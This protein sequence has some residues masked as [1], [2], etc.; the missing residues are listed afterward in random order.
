MVLLTTTSWSTM[1]FILAFTS[2]IYVLI[3]THVIVCFNGS[4]YAMNPFCASWDQH[5]L[6][7]NIIVCFMRSLCSITSL[8]CFTRSK[9]CYHSILLCASWDHYIVPRQKKSLRS[10]LSVLPYF[11]DTQPDF[12]MLSLSHTVNSNLVQCFQKAK[13]C[14]NKT[15][16]ISTANTSRCF[17]HTNYRI[18][19]T[20][21]V[22]Y[23]S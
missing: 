19:S 23:V 18:Y 4:L 20:P 11:L 5:M 12:I 15:F 17:N 22:C 8:V 7:V 2:Q 9:I 21:L 6:P 16:V 14:Y 1:D 10:L 13:Q 3:S